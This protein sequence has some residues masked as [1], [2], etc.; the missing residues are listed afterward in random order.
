MRPRRN[1]QRPSS[2]PFER[3][4]RPLDTPLNG[5]ERSWPGRRVEAAPLWSSV[6]LRDGNQALPNPMDMRRKHLMFDL[7]VSLGFKDIEVGYPSA[8][9]TDFDFVRSLVDGDGIPDDVTIGVFT[10][11]KPAL[12]DRTIEAISGA[13][14]AVVHLCHATACLWRDVVFEMTPRQVHRMAT[15]AAEH[16][17]ETAR[18]VCS[19]PVRFEYSPETFNMTEPEFVLELSEAMTDICRATPD[20]PLVLNL[21]STV[22]TDPPNVF[23]DQVEWMHRHLSRRDSVVLSV[24][25]HNDRG[26]AVASAEL[27]LMA[28]ADRVEG[29]L[30]GNGERTGNV[31]LATLALNLF[32]RGVDPELDFSDID[33]VRR[34]VEHCNEIEVG[35]RH[36][37]VGDLVYTAFSGT[38]Q[39][40][41]AKGLAALETRAQDACVPV[42]SLRWQVPYLP[43]DPRDVGRTYE[44]VVRL[45]SQSGKGGI[46]Y[47]FRSQYGLDLPP[48]IRR[49]LA[50][51]VQ[52]I[53]DRTGQELRPEGLWQIFHDQY[54]DPAGPVRLR[55]LEEG[56][57]PAVVVA[58]VAVADAPG[59]VLE[60][61]GTATDPASAAVE[62]VRR[63]GYD[64]ELISVSSRRIVD[65]S[66]PT[67]TAGFCELVVDGRH[68]MGASINACQ[69]RAEASAV[70]SAVNRAARLGNG[71]RAGRDR[72]VRGESEVIDE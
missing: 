3:Y 33:H 56:R 31:C 58:V 66:D 10:P 14:R 60:F 46:A 5:P 15:G 35:P 6:D 57:D 64:V 69:D 29:T 9:R 24:H 59:R 32:T 21:P 40:A 18:G 68:V 52:E 72:P 62:G 34:V 22:E 37:Y 12:I 4:V 47:V 65:A 43:V 41:I 42:R 26:T 17:V 70:L 20:A 13:E 38:H 16:M 11:A 50:D 61:F 19:S 30:F 45:N 1:P 67:R 53:V 27:A 49:H 2:M 23:A 44:S 36:P 7:L 51:D 55:V 25:P 54:V 48:S 63:A 39:D 8:S 71:S 28:G